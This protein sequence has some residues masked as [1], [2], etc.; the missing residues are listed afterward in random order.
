MK[1]LPQSKYPLPLTRWN[2]LKW[3]LM[4]N[5]MTWMRQITT[6]VHLHAQENQSNSIVDTLQWWALCSEGWKFPERDI[7]LHSSI[8]APS[9]H[10]LCVSSWKSLLI[11]ATEKFTTLWFCLWVHLHC[12]LLSHFS[13]TFKS[14]HC[15]SFSR[16]TKTTQSQKLLSNFFLFSDSFLNS[17]ATQS[18]LWT[19]ILLTATINICT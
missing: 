1:S 12:F 11:L 3:R 5:K 7:L 9:S 10:H 16:S 2:I 14:F 8:V 18:T 19:L 6:H 4:K 13:F 15:E 17:C